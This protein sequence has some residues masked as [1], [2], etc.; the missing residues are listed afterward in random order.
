MKYLA[1]PRLRA[2]EAEKAIQMGAELGPR[3]LAYEKASE[4]AFRSLRTILVDAGYYAT[5]QGANV[6]RQEFIDPA[7]E[8]V[9][10]EVQQMQQPT[11]QA[12]PQI[13][14]QQ[15]APQAA[16]SA[17]RQAELNKLLGIAP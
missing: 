16:T 11:P 17:L 5:S 2:Y 9:N 10:Q 8:Q 12:Q 14:P 6:V 1:S 13:Q 15:P 4:S 3:N 7:L